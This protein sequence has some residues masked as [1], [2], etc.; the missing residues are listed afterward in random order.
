MR[1]LRR[2]VPQ[3]PSRPGAAFPQGPRGAAP[4]TTA[5]LPSCGGRRGPE[6]F[7]PPLLTLAAGSTP[8]RVS[9]TWLGARPPPS[10]PGL[11]LSAGAAWREFSS[12][13]FQH[14]GGASRFGSRCAARPRRPAHTRAPGTWPWGTR[15]GRRPGPLLERQC[16]GGAARVQRI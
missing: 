15:R 3:V 14:A 7:K 1:G 2:A 12:F 9:R 10:H 13:E 11:D 6:L 8:P 16:P 5:W 4:R